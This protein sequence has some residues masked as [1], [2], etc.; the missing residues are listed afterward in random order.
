MAPNAQSYRGS[1]FVLLPLFTQDL[2]RLST[3]EI[4][5][6]SILTGSARLGWTVGPATGPG[7]HWGI[8]ATWGRRHA[9][10]W[11]WS[12]ANLACAGHCK[13]QAGEDELTFQERQE[14]PAKAVQVNVCPETNNMHFKICS[15]MIE[16]KVLGEKK[17]SDCSLDENHFTHWLEK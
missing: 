1:F 8:S 14:N 16:W 2:R 4:E 10:P 6:T 15:Y 5:S 11:L 12:P 3:E 17:N 9:V 13:A 7:L